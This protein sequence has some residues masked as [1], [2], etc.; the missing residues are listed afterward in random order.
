MPAAVTALYA[1]L[2]VAIARIRRRPLRGLLAALGIAAATAMLGA[3]YAGGRV[4]SELSVQRALARVPAAERALRVVWSGPPSRPYRAIDRPARRA[5]AT[6]A[7]GPAVAT[8]LYRETRFEEGR[9]ALVAGLDDVGR[10]VRLTAGRL[11]RSCTPV[12]CEVV[13]V[14]G[15]RLPVASTGGARLVPV[16]E[17]RLAS[18][19]PFGSVTDLGA[20]AG[21]RRPPATFVAGDVRAVSEM[22]ALAGLYRTYAWS[23]PI[24]PRSLHSWDVGGLLGREA[25]ALSTIGPG[26]SL[27]SI[28][29]PDQ[30]VLDA[31]SRSDTASTRL[32]LVG[33]EIA[34]LLLAFVV[35]AANA[36][37]PDALAER[38]R[39]E[40]RGAR[41]RQIVMFALAEGGWMA[42]LGVAAGAAAAVAAGALVARSA[43]LPAGAV[44]AHSLL[45]PGGLAL[46]I[47]ALVVATA[48]V[49][50]VLL[51]GDGRVGGRL[52][53]VA[54][55]ASLAALA[56]AGARGAANAGS[57]GT[58]PLLP[59]LPLL[60]AVVCG[61]AVARLLPP[62]MRLLERRLREAPAAARIAVVSVAR[63]PLPAAVAAAFLAVALGLGF[64]ASTY[65][66]TLAAGQADQA[67]FAVPADETLREGAQLVRPL[68][69]APLARY[70]S[71]AGGTTAMPVLRLSATAAAS[72]AHPVDLTALGLPASAITGLRWRGDGLPADPVALARRLG[73]GGGASLA[74]PALAGGP[75]TLPVTVD[76]AHVSMA[77]VVQA[78]G[79]DIAVV[80]LGTAPPGRRVL[81]A[82]VPPRLAGGRLVAVQ[83]D[84]TA[85]DSKIAIHQQ[86]EGGAASGLRGTV[87]LGSLRAGTSVVT[88]WSGWVGRGGLMPEPSQGAV[89]VRVALTGATRPLLRPR[90]A[91]DGTPVPVAVS[92]DI[93]RAA[94]GGLIELRFAGVTVP[95]QIV[96][97]GARFPTVDGTF[98]VMEESRL[99]TAVNADDPGSAMPDEIWLRADRAQ[100]VPALDAAVTQPPFTSLART[101]HAATLRSLQADPLSKGIRL[102]LQAAAVLALALSVGGLVLAV[103]SAVRDDR[104]ALFDL[105]AQ[106]VPPAVLRRQLRIRAVIVAAVGLAAAL[107]IGLALSAATVA[108]VQVTATAGV[109]VPPL[110]RHMAWPVVA[111]GLAAFLLIAAA[112]VTL[113]TH[114]AFSAPLPA[115]PGGDMP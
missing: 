19:L 92:A 21:H 108:L 49:V 99:A 46:G 107:V 24:D 90:E 36:L 91:T 82:T 104:T 114:A 43:G 5:L 110:Q 11:P 25:R 86:G 80:R 30:A 64:F 94:Q 102:V 10:Y 55:V 89:R 34:A 88:D 113:A 31:T 70:R 47:A 93:A 39:L 18:A 79:G 12:R 51:L 115:R 60:V 45:A 100:D 40:R 62:L 23:R 96:A 33:G 53:D 59:L 66:E 22:P 73:A 26:D 4:S 87:T 7:G 101:S 29:A 77:L 83:I 2:A 103:A 105:E 42:L 67:A 75:L 95:A 61:V 85:A 1:P 63:E 27:W 9:I 37:R 71:L 78:A 111:G 68:D 8:V 54:A 20:S 28:S 76:G 44:L 97:V 65:R 16:G 112:S 98:A 56:L 84:R 13:Q 15:E 69:A 106:G 41:R 50:G 81:T 57:D 3:T 14:A 52:A 74:G 38:R 6:L 17:G 32:T 58:D 35:L 72:G 48:V 109:P